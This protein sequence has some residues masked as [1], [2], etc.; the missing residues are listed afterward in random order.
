MLSQQTTETGGVMAAKAAPPVAVIG[1]QFMGFQVPDL[2]QWITLAYVV[3][4]FSH[5]A[6]HMGL[7][8]YRFWVLKQRDVKGDE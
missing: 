2:V 6:W 4:M 5:K 1:A 3:L 8:A 7:E